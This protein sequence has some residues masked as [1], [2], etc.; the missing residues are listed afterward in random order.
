M[1]FFVFTVVSVMAIHGMPAP[2]VLNDNHWPT[3]NQ[4]ECAKHLRDQC[5]PEILK[6][7]ETCGIEQLVSCLEREINLTA[8][9]GQCKATRNQ[10][11]SY[12]NTIKSDFLHGNSCPNE[13]DVDMLIKTLTNPDPYD[14]SYDGWYDDWDSEDTYYEEHPDDSFDEKDPNDE[15]DTKSLFSSFKSKLHNVI[16]KI[17][18]N[19]SYE[20]EKEIP[21]DKKGGVN[22]TDAEGDDWL[23][24]DWLTFGE[25]WFW[26]NN[27]TVIGNATY[28]VTSEEEEEVLELTDDESDGLLYDIFGMLEHDD[29]VW[30][31]WEEDNLDDVGD[32]DYDV[33]DGDYLEEDGDYDDEDGG[34]HDEDGSHH[35]KDGGHY[36]K[37]G[38]HHE[39]DGY[40]D[41]GDHHEDG[42]YHEV[43]YH[44]GDYH[45]GDYHE[46]DYHEGDNHEGDNHEGDYSEGAYETD[47]SLDL[48]AFGEEYA[49]KG[50]LDGT[51]YGEETTDSYGTE[52]L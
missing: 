20:E 3:E 51:G 30:E 18:G 23:P 36:E 2:R 8:S 29:E 27:S 12:M 47:G 16:E 6:A 39:E 11:M 26:E 5:I 49:P 45:E 4:H 7:N 32:W 42:D 48:D 41:E 19:E 10:M 37:D 14:D 44:E 38:G 15:N 17:F 43:D 21:E 22:T 46:G 50:T 31:E 52:S 35:E 34:Y 40:L 24:F 25:D 13:D 33:G 9:C 1:K 28:N